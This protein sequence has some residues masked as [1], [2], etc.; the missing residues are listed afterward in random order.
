[1]ADTEGSGLLA[2][3]PGPLSVLREGELFD[4][5]GAPV[6]LSALATK[7]VVLIYFGAAWCP[8]CRAFSPVLS[9]FAAHHPRNSEFAVLF[10][11]ADHSEQAM[12][13]FAKGK[14]FTSVSYNAS[15]RR[16][17]GNAMGVSMYPSLYVING[18]TGETLTTWGRSLLQTDVRTRCQ[19][20]IIWPLFQ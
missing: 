9:S 5:D 3:L 18:Q 6:P 4:R 8:P 15:A 1:M 20:H 19:F 11:S 12:A 16:G 10:V 17:I 13:A 7:K 14:H 2:S